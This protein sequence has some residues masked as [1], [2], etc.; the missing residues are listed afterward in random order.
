MKVSAN[1]DIWK[2]LVMDGIDLGDLKYSLRFRN[3]NQFAIDEM[4][5]VVDYVEEMY[6]GLSDE[7][8]IEEWDSLME[9]LNVV[10]AYVKGFFDYEDVV[11][12]LS[13]EYPWADWP[14]YKTKYVAL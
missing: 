1:S 10:K 2:S 8:L 14:W 12:I 4:R 3:D 9:T 13:D 5:A 6:W 11:Q 7:D